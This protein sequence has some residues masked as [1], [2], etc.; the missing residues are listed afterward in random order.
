[1][2]AGKSFE[3]NQGNIIDLSDDALEF[4]KLMAS[5]D[6]FE[7]EQYTKEVLGK[8]LILG[9]AARDCTPTALILRIDRPLM[10]GQLVQTQAIEILSDAAM[11]GLDR[12]KGNELTYSVNHSIYNQLFERFT[13]ESHSEFVNSLAWAIDIKRNLVTDPNYE[14]SFQDRQGYKV[15]EA[16]MLRAS[17]MIFKDMFLGVAIARNVPAKYSDYFERMIDP[18]IAMEFL[19]IKY[20]QDAVSRVESLKRPELDNE[21]RFCVWALT[22]ARKVRSENLDKFVVRTI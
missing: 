13:D 4:Q 20:W 16:R 18:V 11:A 12:L 2:P 17:H 21:K 3:Q 1:M 19:D 14:P 8:L 10:D 6:N 22:K 5:H 9:V 15:F 7:N